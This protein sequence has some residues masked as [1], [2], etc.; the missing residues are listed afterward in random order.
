MRGVNLGNPLK[1]LVVGCGYMGSCHTF[2]YHEIGGFEVVGLVSRGFQS[3]E[4]LNKQFG[5]IYP[6]F[7]DFKQALKT[8]RPDVV[9]I[10]TY[11]DTH[12][13]Y[14]VSAFKAGC[15]VFL[16]K[17]VATTTRGCRRVI[18]EAKNA[19]KKLLVG[20]I[21]RYDPSW[22][23]FVEIAGTLGKP[24]VMRM[25]LIRQSSGKL[26]ERQKKLMNAASPIVDAGVHYTDIMSQMTGADPIRVTAIGARLS[27]ELATG[28]YN[29]GQ[30]QVTFSDG[31]VGWFESGWG[32]MM[33]E[34][35][36]QILDVSG[37]KGSASIKAHGKKTENTYITLHHSALDGENTFVHKDE[38]ID[39][40]NKPDHNE[41]CKREQQ[42]LLEA[43]QE[44]LDLSDHM[45]DAMNSL[46]I[47]LAADE[48]IKTGKTIE[49][50]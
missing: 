28:M 29:Y 21:L 18:D 49:F 39:L 3:R 12:Q 16:E 27:D 13:E 33:S 48:S 5:S 19:N 31:S 23:K 1:V 6:L 8:T 2:A 10:N 11:P 35:T 50:Q 36:L 46:R 25:N 45:N 44:D 20:Y 4:S 15:H 30:L 22:N 34:S 17:P 43:I 14:A 24:L 37:P 32:P 7:D 26:W 41:L 9:S 47:V 38:I 40:S 42:F